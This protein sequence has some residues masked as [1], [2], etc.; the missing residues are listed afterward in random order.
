MSVGDGN[1]EDRETRK[2]ENRQSKLEWMKMRK[3]E[4]IEKEN[5]SMK[6]N[7]TDIDRENYR[8]EREESRKR[9]MD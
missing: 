9:W 2:G 6:K 4:E 3:E 1:D 8:L 7:S 5:S